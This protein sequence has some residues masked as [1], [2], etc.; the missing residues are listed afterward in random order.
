MRLILFIILSF[1]ILNPGFGKTIRV[2]PGTSVPSIKAALRLA[3]NGDSI[4]VSKGSYKEQNIVIEKS[5]FLVGIDRPVLDGE[6]KY[7]ILTVKANFVI[8]DGFDFM[9]AGKSSYIDLAAL[10]VI[11]ASDVLIK[12]N[13]FENSFFGIYCQQS[14]RTVIYKNTLRSNAKDEINSANGI[15]CWKSDQL[16]ILQNTIS[17][18]RDGIYFEFVTNSTI[19]HNNSFNNIRY[20]LHFMFSNYDQYIANSFREN[21]AGVAVMFSNHITMHRNIFSEN[22]GNAA[23][24]ILMKEISDGDVEGNIFNRNTVGIYLE[25]SNRISMKHNHFDDNGWAIKM[26]ASCS[27]NKVEENNFTS[28]TFDV[29]TNGSLVLNKFSGNYWERYEGY[30]LNR[31][32]KGDIPYRPVSLYS[33]I[34]ERNPA[35]LMLFRSFMVD[36]MDRAERIIPGFTPEDLKD[37]EPKMRMIRF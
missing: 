13:Y 21:G 23:Y 26:Q 2:S 6:N 1:P 28:N 31:D 3:S 25:G 35:T 7:E 37:D 22:W 29:A 15:H 27:D 4:L 30:D 18:H 5:V 19:E 9:H 14:T 33:M 16:K 36:L 10:K 24:G 8:I 20:G 11:D 12:N 17:G 34:V 32:G